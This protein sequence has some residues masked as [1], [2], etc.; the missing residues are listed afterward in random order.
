MI[1]DKER[2]KIEADATWRANVNSEI[3]SMWA[4]IR[5]I[6]IGFGM[7][8]IAIAGSIWAQIEKGLFR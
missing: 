3:K 5:I 6:V 7:A 4:I 8:A 2:E 1:E